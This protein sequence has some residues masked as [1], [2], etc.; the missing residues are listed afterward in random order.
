M[1][2]III[3]IIIIIIA[4]IILLKSIL[5]GFHWMSFSVT[6]AH[7]CIVLFYSVYPFVGV[8]A[9]GWDVDTAG[10]GGGSIPQA[11]G[12]CMVNRR[13]VLGTWPPLNECC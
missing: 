6:D 1:V 4:I 7:V 8:E 11:L 10:H 12:C 5:I 2:F 3:I 13:V 9:S